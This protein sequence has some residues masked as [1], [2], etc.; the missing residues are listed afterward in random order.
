MLSISNP[1]T[2]DAGINPIVLVLLVVCAVI[3]IGCIIW[4]VVLGRKNSKI[5]T[6]VITVTDDDEIEIEETVVEDI[7]AEDE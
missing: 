6:T 4:A 3:V 5:E 7:P 2:G 1:A